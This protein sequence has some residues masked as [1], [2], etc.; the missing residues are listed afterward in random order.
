M[1]GLLPDKSAAIHVSFLSMEKVWNTL[2]YAIGHIQII[3]HVKI[4]C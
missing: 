2:Q 4:L 3:C 1:T